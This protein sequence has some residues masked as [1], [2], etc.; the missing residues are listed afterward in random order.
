[1]AT[2]L[3]QVVGTAVGS[4]LGGPIGAAIGSAVGATAGNFL[5]RSLLAGGPAHYEGPRLSSLNGITAAEGAPIPRLYGRARLGG[6]VIWATALEEVATRSKVRSGG[7]GSPSTPT[8]TTYSYFANVAI[9]L[10]EG[11]I[12]FVRRVWA[13]GKLLDLTTV[14]M[15]VYRGDEAQRPDPLIVAK[16]GRA[17]LPGYRGLAYVVFERLPLADYGNRL[18]VLSF[19]VVRPV[20]GL[21]RMVRAIDLIPGATEFGYETSPV[22]RLAGYGVSAGENRNQLTHRTDFQA[23]LDALQA[24][25]PNLVSVALVVAWFGDDLRAGHCT[26]R[27]KVNLTEKVTSGMEWA[28]AG[29]TRSVADQVSKVD[30]RPAFG[31]TP[32]DASVL[33]AIADLKLRGLSVTLYPFIMMDVPAGNAL[34]SPYGGTGQPPYPWRGRITCD[35][36]PGQPGSSDRSSAAEQQV[37]AFFGAASASGFGTVLS[38]ERVVVS[39]AGDIGDGI[40][41]YADQPGSLAYSGAALDWGLRRFI[42]HHAALARLAG[43][44]D[45]FLIGSEMVALTRIRGADGQFPAVSA[46]KQVAGDVRN[47]LGPQTRI[48]YAADWTEY[49]GYVVDAD[50]RFPLDPLW[51]DPAIDF[52]G[53]D[54][55]APLSDWRDGR[56]HLDAALA[57]SIHDLDYLTA[58]IRSGEAFDWYYASA[59]DRDAQRRTPITD[60]AYGKPWVYRQK[61]IASWW[62]YPHHE[63]LNGIEQPGPTAW[64]PQSKPVWLTE[65]GIPAVDKGTNAPNVFPDPKSSESAYPHYSRGS[66]DDLIQARGIE[67]LYRAFDPGHPEYVPGSNPVSAI[68]GGPMIDPDRIHLWTWDARPFPAFPHVTEV[69]SDGAN[70]TTGH[71]LTG[72]LE[73]VPLDRLIEA[74]LADF[75]LDAPLFTD[76]DG[77]VDGYVI[78]RPLTPRAAL[79]PIASLYGVEAIVASGRL[80]FSGRRADQGRAIE[81]FDCVPDRAGQ[82][83]NRS[84]VQESELPHEVSINFVESALDYRPLSV[85]SRKLAGG[86]KRET[87]IAV[88]ALLP[89]AEAQRLADTALQEAWAG[90]DSL[91]LTLR[92]GLLDLEVGD[93]ISLFEPG[94]PRLYRLTA[95]TDGLAR[96]A[97]A[98]AVE[99]SIYDAAA[100]ASTLAT[101]PSASV[102]G[103]PY[104]LVLDLPAAEG[105]PVGLQYVAASAAPWPGGLTIW[106]SA[107]GNSFTPALTLAQPAIH[108]VTS[109]P[110]GAGPLWRWDE[111]NSLTVRLA[112]G[113]LS[114]LD[115]GAVLAGGNTIALRGADGAWELLGFARADLVGVGTYRLSRLLRGL[116]GSEP[117]AMREVPA[118]QPFVVLDEAVGTLAAGVSSLEHAFL[119]RVAP[120]DRDYTDPSAIAFKAVVTGLALQPLAPVHLKASRSAIGVTLGWTRRSRVDGDPWGPL[121][122]PLGESSESYLVE[123]SDGP[124]LRRSIT[125]ATPSLVYAAADELADF[126]SPQSVL[127]IRVRQ[128]SAEVGPGAPLE[129]L[130]RVA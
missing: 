66:R 35:P 99:P 8:Q 79:E 75:G 129:T 36:A 102:A 47:V 114:S 14:T 81:V 40:P 17:D 59:E 63:R 121:E 116:R 70:W 92:P 90:R 54:F 122:I 110:L 64:V 84:R 56:D 45:G 38:A 67:A 119:Y 80:R 22:T 101:L 6:Q 60:G 118:G 39:Y 57:H 43:G 61:D 108:G 31:G 123:I 65:F 25:C 113:S 124:T 73:G 100:G 97:S 52:V 68:Y 33:H 4:V 53:I 93:L 76:V 10:C 49:G 34:P 48:G 71:W 16:E 18:P 91:E 15:R 27:P 1:M 98:R 2:L 62:S 58:R 95:L 20:Q 69:W 88:A 9:G 5:D 55:Y 85:S 117:Q 13:D 11:E 32:S 41:V 120:S 50:L 44:V 21:A 29:L 12:A 106:R 86:S 26:I 89:R 87:R 104:L 126:G 103:P 127:S 72:R 37:A 30:G 83:V 77:F 94:G 78:D 107:E 74:M 96:V 3:L 7:K 115:P 42:L 24:L 82:L 130:V 125:V 128:I 28:A 105:D 111:A 112:R 19:E 109:S 23:S 46:L 51:A